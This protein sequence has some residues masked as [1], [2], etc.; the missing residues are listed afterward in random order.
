MQRFPVC[1]DIPSIKLYT[2]FSSREDVVRLREKLEAEIAR[3]ERD[4]GRSWIQQILG[5]S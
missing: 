1:C 3:Y 2:C 4:G 5:M